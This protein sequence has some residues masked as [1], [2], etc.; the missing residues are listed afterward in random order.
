MFS[1]IPEP[2]QRRMKFLER[3]DENDRINKTD[4]LSR[5]RQVPPETGKFL[6]ILASNCPEGS[7]IEIGTSAGYSTLWISLAA[8]ER[9]ATIR[10]FELLDNK[11]KLARETFTT[12]GISD[13]IELIEG[14]A[15]KN[16]PDIEDI[17]FCFID[18]EK[19]L[20]E[21]CW[22]LISGKI[23]KNGLVVADN[24]ISHYEEIKPMINK[25]FAD[26]RFD[27]LIVPIGAGELVCRRK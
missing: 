16:I 10:T 2:M 3:I 19:E 25:A 11:I 22:E 15:L 18:L 9:N 24:A 20:Y 7:F 5:L 1:E 17:S 26:R 23:V 12:S 8:K 27:C 6:A 14:D 4:Q 21:K 13:F